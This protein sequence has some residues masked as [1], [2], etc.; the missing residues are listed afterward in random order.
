MFKQFG[1]LLFFY[2]CIITTFRPIV[3]VC[4]LRIA[5]KVLP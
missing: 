5:R 1:N 3:T 4:I 2:A